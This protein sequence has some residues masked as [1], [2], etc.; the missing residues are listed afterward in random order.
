MPASI[1]KLSSARQIRAATTQSLANKGKARSEPQ[2]LRMMEKKME[3][4]GI[5]GFGVGVY[6]DNGK[7][8]GKGLGFRVIVPLK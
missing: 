7:E 3:A 8:N 5:I 4:I 6:W 2:G 1:S